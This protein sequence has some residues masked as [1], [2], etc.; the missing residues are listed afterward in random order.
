LQ[1]S[2]LRPNRC[3][4]CAAA[5]LGG[6]VALRTFPGHGGDDRFVQR[7]GFGGEILVAADKLREPV[8]AG[9]EPYRELVDRGRSGGLG[10]TL[11]DV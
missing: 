10:A 6:E 8:A 4:P 9:G 2:A 5:L 1:G 11:Q 3:Q 7:L